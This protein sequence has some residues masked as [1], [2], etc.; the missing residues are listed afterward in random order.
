MP[1]PCL[2]QWYEVNKHML[3]QPTGTPRLAALNGGGLQPAGSGSL[4]SSQPGTPRSPRAGQ[5]ASQAPPAAQAPGNAPEQREGGGAA[6]GAAA[7]LPDVAQA[8]LLHYRQTSRNL[9]FDARELAAF[10]ERLQALAAQQAAQQGGAAAGPPPS[11]L[12]PQHRLSRLSQMSIKA[13]RPVPAAGA[14]AGPE[15]EIPVPT[16]PFAAASFPEFPS[17]RQR[18]G[19]AAAAE[20]AGPAEPAPAGVEGEASRP[21]LSAQSSPQSQPVPADSPTTATPRSAAEPAGLAASAE[22]APVQAG[23]HLASHS[24]G[25]D[26]CASSPIRASGGSRG[27]SPRSK[28][29]SV[30]SIGLTKQPSGAHAETGKGPAAQV[31]PLSDPRGSGDSALASAERS[32]SDRSGGSMQ[33]S[34][35][36]SAGPPSSSPGGAFSRLRRSLTGSSGAKKK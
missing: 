18:Q 20:P 29:R 1:S 33:G 24:L 36:A 16:S 27:S 17:E 3:A 25:L 13:P 5:Q 21:F 23:T 11:G 31:V 8:G 19:L 34:L 10:H 7:S 14:P 4:G 15:P 35:A 32:G 26:S 30:P 9:S 22:L 6:R 12:P 28:Q 2:V